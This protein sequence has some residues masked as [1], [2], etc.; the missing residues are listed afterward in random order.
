MLA[1]RRACLLCGGAGALLLLS[2]AQLLWVSRLAPP[3]PRAE[4]EGAA[5][6][7]GAREEAAPQPGVPQGASEAEA[8]A[9]AEDDED[10]GEAE[11]EAED[12][13]ESEDGESEEGKP[14]PK[15]APAPQVQVVERR[16]TGL[17]AGLAAGVGSGSES[18]ES[19]LG[20]APGAPR[21]AWRAVGDA[22]VER[23]FASLDLAALAPP[24][25]EDEYDEVI[26]GGGPGADDDEDG[27]DN[28]EELL[29]EGKEGDSARRQ[30][31]ARFR[32]D[33]DALVAKRDRLGT[34]LELEGLAKVIEG[35]LEPPPKSKSSA[36]VVQSAEAVME[37]ARWSAA[38]ALD[39]EPA[40]SPEF[41]IAP[42]LPPAHAAV[43][44][45]ALRDVAGMRERAE[46]SDA[47]QEELFQG[48]GSGS[49]SGS[50]SGPRSRSP[51]RLLVLPWTASSALMSIYAA[52]ARSESSGADAVVFGR[53]AASDVFSWALV[54]RRQELVAALEAHALRAGCGA[55]AQP[56]F[57]PP[58][59]RVVSEPRECVAL[60]GSQS[61]EDNR[62]VPWVVKQFAAL[63]CPPRPDPASAP[64]IEAGAPP[65]VVRG[66]AAVRNQYGRCAG[67]ASALDPVLLERALLRPLLVR[68]RR[69][70]LHALVLV[71]GTAPWRARFSRGFATLASPEART[72]EGFAGAAVASTEQLARETTDPRAQP[73]LHGGEVPLWGHARLERHLESFGLCH[74]RGGAGAGA[75]EGEGD[76][77]A[78]MWA[79]VRAVARLLLD[80]S[81]AVHVDARRAGSGRPPRAF[82]VFRIAFSLDEQLVP[83]LQRGS[84]DLGMLLDEYPGEQGEALRGD[85]ARLLA[86]AAALAAGLKQD[87]T[88]WEPLKDQL[89][90]QCG[91]QVAQPDSCALFSAPPR[92][93][94]K[95][96]PE[97][98]TGERPPPA[99][100]QQVR[101]SAADLA[102][103][104][105]AHGA[106]DADDAH[107]AHYADDARDA[108]DAGDATKARVTTRDQFVRVLEPGEPRESPKGPLPTTRR[109]PRL[110]VDAF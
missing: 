95:Q 105:D 58:S 82:Q 1:R 70:K 13:D 9:V 6:L 90:E 50:G 29:A 84:A 17:A 16:A 88:L 108:D 46:A 30:Q 37:C 44:R 71:L 45:L 36:H 109:E 53:L 48:S 55:G 77:C 4:P 42:S 54:A 104:R 49:E 92:T 110:P 102:S 52:A 86:D 103:A 65:L 22:E 75:G 32:R 5:L 98:A 99:A 21:P 15:P 100:S 66:L 10:G 47:T 64:C 83:T 78:A 76:R 79:Q 39:S 61:D 60:F 41:S 12:D 27:D 96:H 97:A 85:V 69:L 87:S 26:G 106:R 19:L 34:A 67:A 35:A 14:K 20:P 73:P 80:A 63:A 40:A 89:A 56:L 2:G 25:R 72:E 33:L 101:Q 3:A 43:W 68:S 59:F 107:D 24:P 81:A 8:E 7:A 62:D 38:A 94:D 51:P 18:L 91:G 74:P 31:L 57:R 28:A 23:W 93:P 11:P